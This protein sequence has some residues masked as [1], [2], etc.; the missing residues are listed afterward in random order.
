MATL[1]SKINLNWASDIIGLMQSAGKDFNS[2]DIMLGEV[3][4][5]PPALTIKVG[6]IVLY[7]EQLLVADYL[8]PGYK[9][10][11]YQEGVLHFRATADTELTGNTKPTATLAAS[12]L[13]AAVGDHG[14]HDHGTHT[15]P[16]HSHALKD[17][18]VTTHKDN[19][20]AHGDGSDPVITDGRFN[21]TAAAEKYFYFT[22]TLK[23]KDLVLVQQIPGT[24]YFVV[25]NR[26]VRMEEMQK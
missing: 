22:D 16:E 18:D 6:N 8:L 12:V 26:L 10:A 17:I 15:H 20:F 7:P 5:P 23:P 14:S 2:P 21:G 11:Y 24:H 13:S 1:Q 4:T 9:R 25:K 3:I 19:F